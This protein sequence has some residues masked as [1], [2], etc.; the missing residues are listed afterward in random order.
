[1]G[2]HV[3]TTQGL[4][5]ASVLPRHVFTARSCHCCRATLT[6][7]CQPTAESREQREVVAVVEVWVRGDRE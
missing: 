2:P 5:C 3:Y 1:M 4:D 6:L 7:R